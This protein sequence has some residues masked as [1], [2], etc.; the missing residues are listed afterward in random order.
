MAKLSQPKTN[1]L[2]PIGVIKPGLKAVSTSTYKLPENK[3]IP[4]VKNIAAKTKAREA[5]CCASN[6]TNNKAKAWIN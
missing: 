4:K 2:P 3:I 5:R 6:A 1:K